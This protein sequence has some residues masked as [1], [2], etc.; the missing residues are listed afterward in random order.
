MIEPLHKYNEKYLIATATVTAPKDRKNFNR[1]LNHTKSNSTLYSHQKV[2]FLNEAP[3][4]CIVCC[5]KFS[6]EGVQPYLEAIFAEDLQKFNNE[7]RQLAQK[8]I[9]Q[10]SNVLARDKWDQGRFDLH[11]FKNNLKEDAQP[12]K[13]PYPSTN[14]TKWKGLNKFLNTY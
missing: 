14:P 8:L 11:N 2:A 12:S 9:E 10:Y 1:I 4:N 3:T 13:V 5:V 7:Q 6:D